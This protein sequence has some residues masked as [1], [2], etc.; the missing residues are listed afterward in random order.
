MEQSRRR[1]PDMDPS[2]PDKPAEKP[3]PPPAQPSGGVSKP[4]PPSGRKPRTSRGAGQPRKDAGQREE[5]RRARERFD[6]EGG[7]QK[8]GGPPHPSRGT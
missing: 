4:H 1:S 8:Q 7:N 2:A 3:Q 5:D 6:A